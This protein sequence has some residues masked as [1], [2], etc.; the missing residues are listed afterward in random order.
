MLE[1]LLRD[2]RFS[3]TLDI[4]SPKKL[5]YIR[6]ELLPVKRTMMRR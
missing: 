1:T 5:P 4:K 3:E 6:S 2:E